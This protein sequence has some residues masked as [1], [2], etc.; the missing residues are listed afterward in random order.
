MVGEELEREDR[1]Q[2]LEDPVGTGDLDRFFG[3]LA[4]PVVA[5]GCDCD[6]IG[7]TEINPPLDP[8][9]TGWIASQRVHEVLAVAAANGITRYRC[10]NRGFSGNTFGDAMFEQ[11]A[12]LRV[13]QQRLA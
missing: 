2:W 9:D 13:N 11:L 12:G 6:H 5:F 7:A 1:D 10:G 8:N 4:D 3:D